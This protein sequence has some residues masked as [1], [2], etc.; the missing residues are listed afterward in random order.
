MGIRRLFTEHPASVGET[1][2]QHLCTACGFAVRMFG[3]GIACFLHA[4]FP[5][6]FQHTGSDCIASLYDEMMR[7]R[8]LGASA[9]ALQATR[10]RAAH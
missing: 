6:A 3:A 5:F 7:R 9:A 2:L 8:R 4:L 10:A 1:Y